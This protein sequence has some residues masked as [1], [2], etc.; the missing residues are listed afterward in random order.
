MRY[1]S[2]V[3]LVCFSWWATAQ[4]F[5][6]QDI[7]LQQI[8]DDLYGFQDQDLNYE[9]IYE[10]LVLL[11]SSPIDLNKASAEDF[12]F[13]K[14]LSE[15]QIKNILD[16]RTENGDFLSVYELQAVP[17]FT[18]EFIYQV[19]PF[20]KVVS[21]SE[22][23]DAS[24]IKRIQTES[25]NYFLL[26]YERLLQTKKGFQSDVDPEDQ[27]KG[28]AGKIYMR[29]RSSQPGDFSFGF[30]LE[31]DAGEQMQWSKNYYGFDY[32]SIH[33]QLQNKGRLKNFI[34]GDYQCQFGQGIM[35]GG[36]F[37]MG[38]GGETITTTRRSNI[39]LLP[40]T[41]A[42]EVGALRGG[43]ATVEI[44]PDLTFTAFFS[45]SKRDATRSLIVEDDPYISSFQTTGLHRNEKELSTRQAVGE[46]NIGGVLQYTHNQLDVGVLY[47]TVTFD[48]VINRAPTLYNQFYFNG[49]QNQNVGLFMNYT[50]QNVSF[51]SEFAKSIHGG[52]AH[53]AGVLWSLT[54]KFD[55]SLLHR[56]YD[57]NFYSFYS[58]AFAESSLPQNERG[59]YG[60]WKYRFNRKFSTAGYVDFFR[61]PWLRYRSYR[62]SNGH[63]WLLRVSYQ[64]ARNITLFIQ[65][66]EELKVR[67]TSETRGNLYQTFEGVKRNYW[68]SANYTITKALRMKTRAQCSSFT[69]RQQTTNGLALLQ[70]I[71]IDF[72]KLKLTT[73]YS[74]FDTDD[75]DNRQYA[76]ENDVWLAYSLPAYEGVGVRNYW[77]LEYTFNKFINV[78]FRYA[79]TRYTD[80]EE[81]GSG[82]DAIEGNVRSDI[83]I[84]ACLKF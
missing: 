51:F 30:T 52:Q 56:K 24:L 78:W 43:A 13:M 26:R 44:V 22:A 33:V 76:Y 75:Y 71:Q 53:V 63:E 29:F 67:N 1:F 11:L 18:R 21:A 65:A 61:F 34:V 17:T 42:Y 15:S 35:L 38:K 81:I 49:K 7:N 77:L 20:V 62:P 66:R 31:K 50:F 47:N 10:N 27:F 69:F 83:K 40:Y 9:E 25:D 58:N 37:G 14:I 46:Q 84:Q 54:S 23:L 6:R 72:G 19:V 12:R 80:R 41:S 48:G 73:R 5:P 3:G 2:I 82:M 55:I 32:T 45:K 59:M 57:R 28:S 70:D 60:G 4:E 64:P 36:I 16:Y 79:Q 74:L 39:G 8:A 68:F